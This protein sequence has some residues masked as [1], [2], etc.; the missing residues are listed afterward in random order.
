L[1]DEEEERKR[2]EEGQRKEDRRAWLGEPIEHGGQYLAPKGPSW[3][4]EAGCC[5][6]EAAGSVG[7][8]AALVVLP[9]WLLL[10]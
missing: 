1:S 2:E 3:A 4:P 9:A 8:I 6:F 7:V 10:S 5:L